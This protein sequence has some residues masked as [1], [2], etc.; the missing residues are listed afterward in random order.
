MSA[1]DDIMTVGPAHDR[2]RAFDLPH[3][4][5]GAPSGI[6]LTIAGP[7]G[8]IARTAQHALLDGLAE[9][10]GPDGRVSAEARERLR[11]D[12][13]ARVVLGW[14]GDGLPAFSALAVRQALEASPYLARATDAMAGSRDHYAPDT[15]RPAPSGVD[16]LQAMAAILAQGKPGMGE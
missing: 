4:L 2:G 3:P 14:E 5:T 10:T 11:L 6:R 7:D 16:A 15:G 9:A 13:L 8:R 12:A 1:W